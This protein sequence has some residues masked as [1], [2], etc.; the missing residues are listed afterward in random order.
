LAALLLCAAPSAVAQEQRDKVAPRRETD[1]PSSESPNASA[2]PAAS[3]NA[4][5]QA[6]VP[7]PAPAPDS[8]PASAPGS[9]S[10]SP[11]TPTPG[12]RRVPDD[13][14]P[15][16]RR[17][18]DPAPLP[19]PLPPIAAPPPTYGARATATRTRNARPNVATVTR[20]DRP[21]VDRSP[22]LTSD[23][24]LRALPSVATFRRSSSLVADP[25][26]Q[27]LNLRGLAPS[28]V[29]RT[30]VLLDGVPLND[31]FG[32]WVYWRS[33]PRL[34][35]D[36]IEVVPGG[37]SALYGSAALG[38]VVQ[39]YAR[40]PSQEG[41]DADLSYGNLDT[42]TLGLR[43]AHQ[44]D[45][46]GAAIEG[47][48]LTSDGYRIVSGADR[49]P[50]DG[51]TP[52]EHGNISGRFT[53]DVTRKLRIST[54]LSFFRE[55]QNGG[56]RFTTS[57][58]SLGLASLGVAYETKNA[59]QFELSLFGRRELFGQVRARIDEARETEA[60]SGEQSV[61]SGD[62]GG[63]LTWT[64]P[65]VSGFGTHQFLAG[66]DA[67]HI[68]GKSTDRLYPA[69]TQPDSV[70]VKHISGEQWSAGGFVQDLV[71]ITE[72][73]D[74]QASLRGD[75]WRNYDADRSLERASGDVTQSRGRARQE[76]TLSPR[77]GVLVHLQPWLRL[78]AA[79]YRAF[80]APTLN[81]L[82]RSFQVGTILTAAN[83]RLGPEHVLGGE[84]G[85]E[86]AT[87]S[88]RLRL[89][90]FYN[91]LDDPIVNATLSAPLP[92]GSTRQRQNLGAAQVYGF[93]FDARYAFNP[94]TRFD[95]AYTLA[96]SEVTD[97]GVMRTLVGKRLP[98]DPEHRATFGVMFEQPRW[99]SGMV[100]VRVVGPQWEDDLN[101]LSMNGFAVLD[102]FASRI[103]AGGLE[104]F[105]GAENI[106][107]V[108]YLVGRAGVDTLGAPF[109][110]RVGL[111]LR[112]QYR[113]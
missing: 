78:R 49:G 36:H 60:R 67:R 110:F 66:I 4:A 23:G 26:S 91:H 59:G 82:Y 38:G 48:W 99:F 21:R 73:I 33:V 111:R 41:V 5:D 44:F 55:V 88:A 77:L 18:P 16:L 42:L 32:G 34:G 80:R 75:L 13:G 64:S 53:L 3:T 28:G 40:P 81:E 22:S 43:F 97:A 106:L 50:V 6:L 108:R 107:N 46:F 83:D 113:P 14:T 94:Y 105:A 2:P 58:V 92:D 84:L 79:G 100:Q 90:G 1:L 47:D 104:V 29:S 69:M 19:F 52:S 15:N 62:E 112:S 65:E 98:Q 45:T 74:L 93:E 9:A 95:F 25:S 85:L 109:T 87:T 70:L 56:T 10:S 68:G 31:P 71:R 76:S 103:L 27:G 20:I 102:A 61:P 54:A 96:R 24:T 57:E 37:G 72:Q 17:V 101:T 12:L 89:T 39:L 7:A 35:L 51:E 8:A 86:F 30:L 11:P 63:A